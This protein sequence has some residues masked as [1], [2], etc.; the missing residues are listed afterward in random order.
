ME[1]N[2]AEDVHTLSLMSYVY[3]LWNRSSTQ[4]NLVITKLN[5][6]AIKSDG[7]IHWERS[8]GAYGSVANIETTAYVLLA[9]LNDA[10][11][12]VIEETI[13]IVRWLTTQRNSY[14]GFSST[15]DTVLALQAL[16]T[17]AGFVYHDEVNVR[18]R[19]SGS[20]LNQTFDVT[21]EN[22]LVLQKQEGLHLPARLLYSVTG[23]GCV[24]AQASVKYNTLVA[25]N[26]Q[27]AAAFFLT[28]QVRNGSSS[29][30]RDNQI[31][32]CARYNGHG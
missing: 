18:I 16:A 29:K 24:L 19:F 28:V 22:R 23:N 2:T 11:L 30:C 32:V 17:F 27:Q 12:E 3:S 1:V 8:T 5:A 13:P 10:G 6:K 7:M 15:Q 26:D 9:L 25:Q 31:H 20:D 21:Q 4:F 14:G